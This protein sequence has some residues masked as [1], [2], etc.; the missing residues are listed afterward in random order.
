M[1]DLKR[2]IDYLIDKYEMEQKLKEE[3][4]S[5]IEWILPL[6]MLALM[7][8]MNQPVGLMP[9]VEIFHEEKGD[10]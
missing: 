9:T 1:K 3:K 5:N 4:N 2:D 8:S 6:V 10:K 7:P